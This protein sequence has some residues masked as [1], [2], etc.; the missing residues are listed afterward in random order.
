LHAL[1]GDRPHWVR[2]PTRYPIHIIVYKKKKSAPGTVKLTL[3]TQ[4]TLFLAQ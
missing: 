1:V 3:W 4:H 2:D